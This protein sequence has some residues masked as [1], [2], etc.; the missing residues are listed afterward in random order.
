MPTGG[1]V[2]IRTEATEITR[3]RAA[4]SPEARAGHFVRL[5]GEGMS[6][7]TLSHIFEPFFT[8]KEIGKGT[9]MGLATVLGIVQQHEGWIE[10]RSTP[11]QGTTCEIYLPVTERAEV[12][13]PRP[14]VQPLR[15]GASEVILLVEDDADVRELARC[16]LE[17]AGYRIIEAADGQQAIVAWREFAG[18]IDL[19]LTDMVMPGGLSGSDVAERFHADRPE[20]KVLFSSGYNVELFG[21]DLSLREGFNYRAKPYLAHQLT[22]AVARALAGAAAPEAAAA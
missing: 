6:A 9:G 12:F 14:V 7:E 11:G 21:G 2:T 18:R 3:Q 5:T 4:L 19:L 8:T 10:T 15:D 16:V 13:E 1:T 22:D 17:D 20:S